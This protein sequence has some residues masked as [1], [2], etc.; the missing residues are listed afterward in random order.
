MALLGTEGRVN[1]WLVATD[2]SPVRRKNVNKKTF[3]KDL[4]D[5]SAAV[6]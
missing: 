6:F 2:R 5:F 3:S 4:H 1:F